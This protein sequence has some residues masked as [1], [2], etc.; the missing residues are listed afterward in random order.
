MPTGTSPLALRLSPFLGR[1]SRGTA[2][3]TDRR[4]GYSSTPHT[5]DCDMLFVPVAGRFDVIDERERCMNSQPGSFVWIG[6]GAAHATAAQTWRQTHIALYVDADLWATALRAQDAADAVQGLRAGSRALSLVAQRISELALS[7]PEADP[8]AYC[9][10]LVMEAARLCGA[11]PVVRE[12]TLASREVVELL[13]DQ[14]EQGLARPLALD[15]F[16]R[17]QRLSRR[18]LERLF[19]DQVGC[20]PLE[21]Q[22][23]KR[24]ERAKHLLQTSQDSVIDIAQQVG[25]ESAHHLSRMTKKAWGLSASQLRTQRGIAQA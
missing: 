5:H 22:Q 3:V 11:R 21:F 19:R 15:D 7:A 14:I 16:A 25:W 8:T 18:Q 13:L 17:R 24:L 23:R 1:L 4:Q 9:G 12:S 10:A 20:A 2:V 6:A